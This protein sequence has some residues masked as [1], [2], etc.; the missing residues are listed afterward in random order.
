MEKYIRFEPGIFLEAMGTYRCESRYL[1]GSQEYFGGYQGILRGCRVSFWVIKIEKFG[2]SV[3][4]NNKY[5]PPE[6][7]VLA[8]RCKKVVFYPFWTHFGHFGG[9]TD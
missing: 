6:I 7:H 8:T 2:L 3:A 1:Q 5:F 4:I 9:F